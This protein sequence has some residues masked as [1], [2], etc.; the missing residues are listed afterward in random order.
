MN[1]INFLGSLFTR[2]SQIVTGYEPLFESIFYGDNT[3]ASPSDSPDVQACLSE[4]IGAVSSLKFRIIRNDIVD[5]NEAFNMF[6]SYPSDT[7]N[8]DDFIS[9]IIEQLYLKGRA[10]IVPTFLNTT[11][12]QNIEIPNPEDM[13]YKDENW[14]WKVSD[15]STIILEPNEVIYLRFPASGGALAYKRPLDVIRKDIELS[16]QAKV[17]NTSFMKNGGHAGGV[18]HLP[19]HAI[20]NEEDKKKL[21]E[22]YKSKFSGSNA[23][24]VLILEHGMDYKASEAT[25][26]D[27]MWLEGITSARRTICAAMKVPPEIIGDH[28]NA[29]YHSYPEARKAFYSECIEPMAK[30]ITYGLNRFLIQNKSQYRIDYD[31]ASVPSVEADTK[32]K[33]DRVIAAT[34]ANIITVD[35]AKRELGLA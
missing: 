25:P 27:V 32:S 34:N 23:G 14:I 9:I 2:S 16:A 13:Q 3:S 29:T 8:W 5:P 6:L 20:V 30:K 22:S 33:W 4:I 11:G 26:K 18:V 35:D 28:E 10:F 15:K 1:K 12:I 19:E 31:P 17:F 21:V 7:L 24:S